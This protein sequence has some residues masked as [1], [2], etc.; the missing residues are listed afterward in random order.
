MQCPLLPEGKATRDLWR[1]TDP[2][3]WAPASSTSLHGWVAGASGLYTI[4]KMYTVN[5]V[6]G[7]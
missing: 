2:I 5:L 7:T 3:A 6:S 4:G 1:P